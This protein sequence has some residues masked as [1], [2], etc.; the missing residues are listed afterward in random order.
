MI[1][2]DSPPPIDVTI[3]SVD[4][5]ITQAFASMYEGSISYKPFPERYS[6]RKEWEGCSGFESSVDSDSSCSSSEEL[7]S[8]AASTTGSSRSRSSSRSSSSTFSTSS[9]F[10]KIFNSSRSSSPSRSSRS[11]HS[12]KPTSLAYL[13]SDST[14]PWN[15]TSLLQIPNSE[16]IKPSTLS[17]TNSR[18]K[19]NHKISVCIRYRL[20]GGEEKLLTLSKKINVASVS[21]PLSPFQSVFFF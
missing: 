12:K 14:L 21:F 20:E 16:I 1:E 7:E 4:T 6:L 10:N 11:S 2:L 17:N 13:S 5:Y 9:R 8:C 3:L 15:Y 19:V 18:L